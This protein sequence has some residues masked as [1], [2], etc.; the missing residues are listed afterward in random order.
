MHFRILDLDGSIKAQDRLVRACEPMIV[1]LR[2]W[3]PKLRLAAR[4]PRFFRFERWLDRKL[5]RQDAEPTTTFVGSGEFHH[6]SLALLRRLRQ[7]F[8]LL[9]L[10]KHPDWVRGVPLLHC[11]TW[12]HHAA[13]LPNV[14][15]IYHLGGD[16]D[17]EN[18]FRWLAPR[19]HLEAGKFV[20]HPACRTYRA[21]FW[22]N[23]PHEPLLPASGGRL[24]E[25]RLS[26]LCLPYLED[27]QRWP[28]YVSLDKDVMTAAEAPVN[29]DS[30]HLHFD[31][32]QT[33]LNFF[34]RASG[35]PLLGMDVVGDWSA[36]AVD[37]WLQQLLHLVEHP[38]LPTT[39]NDAQAL[40]Q[41]VN[42]RL[43]EALTEN[44]STSVPHPAWSV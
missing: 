20:V 41:A 33:I 32:V 14:Q 22:R 7:P 38:A 11:G 3:G 24:T 19:R 31:E 44:R 13:Q 25:E 23:L 39:E 5:P 9:V 6:V 29:W 43:V 26:R 17:F 28:L 12:L 37:S 8:N 10:D 18:A 35:N 16:L 40:N 15:R 21:G 1:D 42:L 2:R 4:W 36:V 30:G 27:L 34:Q